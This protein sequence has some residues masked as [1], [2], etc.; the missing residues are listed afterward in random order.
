MKKITGSGSGGK[1]APKSKKPVETKDNLFSTAYVSIID[2]LG[3]GE[4][5]G[6]KDGAK[7][8]YIDNTPLLG[9]D[10]TA[11][12]SGVSLEVRNGTQD[13]SYVPGFDDISNEISVGVVV[14]RS[15]P[16]ARTI[17]D[18]A[19]NAV[20]VLITIPALQEIK[21]NG[22]LLG[23][24]VRLKIQLQYNGGGYSTIIDDTIQG[25]T[26][27]PYQRQY[28]VG[29]DGAFP[30]DVR[31]YRETEDSTSSSLSN[32]FS[33][34]SY[35]E[36]TYARTT[37]PNTAL[38]ALRVSSEQFNSTPQRSYLIRGL[39]VK[40]PSNAFVHQNNGRVTYIGAWDGTF[41][42]A[43]WCSDP[44]WC[45]WDL[46]TSK[47][48]GL[49]DHI[50]ADQLDKWSF[51]AASQYC[52]ELVP[53]G[54][55]GI[56]PRFSCN[57]NIQSAKDAYDV[58]NEM[59]SV[60]RAMPYWSAGAVSIGQDRPG[61]PVY[62]FT[63]ASV[64]NGDFNYSNSSSKTRPT[65][66]V[67]QYTDLELRDSGYE[68][69]ENIEAIAKYGII[70][71]D[72]VAIACTSRGQA[73]RLG[74]WLLYSEQN[75]KEVCKFVSSVDSGVIVRPGSII[76]IEDSVKNNSRRGGRVFAAT[77]NTI[78]VD[79]ATSLIAGNN[80]RLSVILYDGT[81]QSRNVSS[82]SGNVITLASSLSSIPNKNSVWVFENDLV[83]STTWRV[84]LV[85]EDEGS[86]G[87]KY[88]YTCIAHNPSKYNYI[89]QNVALEQRKITY[90]NA[91]P[92]S[93]K[94]I[95][96][97]QI[98][99]ETTIGISS[100]ISIGWTSV[101]GANSYKISWRVDSGN[102]NSQIVEQNNYDI[103][104][105]VPGVYEISVA[106]INS[107]LQASKPSVLIYQAFGE[108]RPPETP[109]GVSIIAIDQSTA[110]IR[111]DRSISP[112][113][114]L[115]GKVLIRHSSSIGAVAWENSQEIIAGIAGSEVEKQVP[116][117]AGT[118]LV[119]FENNLGVRSVNAASVTAVMPSMQ[120]RLMIKQ[121]REHLETPPF[122]GTYTNMVYSPSANEI[123]LIGTE[124]V[125]S[126]AVD[127]NW[128]G[129]PAIDSIGGISTAGEYD[130][131]E[132]L[133][134]PLMCDLSIKRFL[135]TASYAVN[136][137]IDDYASPIDTWSDSVFSGSSSGDRVNAS[138]YVR[139]SNDA[140]PTFAWGEWR[141]F[142][143]AVVTG[144]SFQFKL[145][146]S[147]TDIG[148]SIS[149][150]EIGVD[151][152][153]QQRVEASETLTSPASPYNVTFLY[154]FYQPP[155]ISI[156]PFNMDHADDYT[157]TSI[158]RTGF[159]IRFQQGGSY[160]SRQF[161]YSATGYGGIVG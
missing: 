64:E 22:D 39:K 41:G 128:D 43:Q 19:V 94:D 100:K 120:P 55:G 144:R 1:G 90:L 33:W 86:G 88:S 61:D 71:Q 84:L 58:I 119:K 18:E 76:K 32:A 17:T 92:A 87:T 77:A 23:A 12:F 14:Q 6:L 45:L 158:T 123:L 159:T 56:E 107:V 37:Y 16:I 106:S 40:L 82:I 160:L 60:F 127:G 3:E 140:G 103:I 27:Q 115:N 7:S 15:T 30:V 134:L 31:V 99:Y 25:K 104:D 4:I 65:V 59:S 153:L 51:F 108:T 85:E 117:L 137:T 69:V 28:S 73:H 125:D 79:D 156:T 151:V 11:N 78:T 114:L 145:A 26:S 136:V 141:E 112:S 150:L 129:L 75:E 126:M 24:K 42:A 81:I 72:V 46:L 62:Q 152:E 57:I 70:R 101:L 34:T 50:Q 157:V 149:I 96:A 91:G 148:Q 97:A 102:W 67:V 110:R 143:N 139:A 135:K 13:Q 44:A 21:S 130:F 133:T 47:R 54:F 147:S 8:I 132:I 111:W 113:V 48:Y 116:L 138:V 68:V 53:D 105:S 89:E 109:T 121:F 155:S 122:S 131:G 35:S 142:A 95:V 5:Q 146:A 63:N 66:A 38:V 9:S 74:K 80:A 2:L 154:P 36:I 118:Y 20:R 29:I 161:T 52:S 98:I 124:T 93:P 10:G 49:G 83:T